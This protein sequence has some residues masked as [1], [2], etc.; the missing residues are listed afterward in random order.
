MGFWN[1]IYTL[2]IVD[3]LEDSHVLN[4]SQR[5]TS[6]Q[7]LRIF[8][9]NGLRVPEHVIDTALYN[10]R[11]CI[12]DAAHSV[13]SMWLKQQPNR[14]EAYMNL[15][16]GLKRAQMNELAAL[17][18]KWVGAVEDASQ[19]TDESRSLKLMLSFLLTRSYTQ[20]AILFTK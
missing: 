4:L 20:Q 14:Q 19:I 1:C 5:I 8:G 9:T 10:Y 16:A 17:V 15:Q 13:L 11:T 12:Q 6:E 7:D 2:Y 18:R 3:T